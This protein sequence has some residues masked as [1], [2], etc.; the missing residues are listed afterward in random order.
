MIGPAWVGD[1]V[2]AHTLV[3]RLRAQDPDAELHMLAPAATAA[4]AARMAEIQTVHSV[5]FLHGEF[6]FSRR[7]RLGKSLRADAF[8]QAFV[9]PNSWKSALIPYFANIPKRTGWLGET[10]YGL[11]NDL[12]RLNKARY[13]LMIE[14]FMA[15]ATPD[16]GLPSPSYPLPQLQVDAHNLARCLSEHQL[17]CDKVAVL[18]PGAEF[19]PAKKWP[20]RHYAQL[21]VRLIAKGWNV[22]MLGSPNDRQDAADIV[23]M[24]GSPAELVNLVGRTTLL[25]AEDLLSVAQQ[26][27]CNDSGLMH[28]ACALGRPTVGIFGSTSASFTPPLGPVGLVVEQALACRPCFSRTCPLGHL[29]CL[30]SLWP[31]QVLSQINVCQTTFVA[32]STDV[33]RQV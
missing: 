17:V 13:G 33:V 23:Q 15:L 21:A 30:E 10:R 29:D 28:V 20:P 5:D 8:D 16:G 4:L 22:W 19:G 6:G 3:Q 27:I 9:L 31:E 25:D 32:S 14:R 7:R 11:L 12:R 26:V 1:M 2:M 24:A 18:C